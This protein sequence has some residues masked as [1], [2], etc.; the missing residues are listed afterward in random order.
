[1]NRERASRFL[2]NILA[3]VIFSKNYASSCWYLN[4]L[5]EIVKCKEESKRLVVILF[6]YGLDHSHVRKQ[7]GDLGKIFEKTCKN[8][9]RG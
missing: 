2:S 1:M 4:E 3:V 7:T 8:M 5:L 6:F 9:N